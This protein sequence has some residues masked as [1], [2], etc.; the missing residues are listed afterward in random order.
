MALASCR[1]TVTKVFGIPAVVGPGLLPK[2]WWLWL[3]RSRALDVLKTLSAGRGHW[4]RGPV[5]RRL[6]LG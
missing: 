6:T 2:V 5:V 3:W 4:R 1:T